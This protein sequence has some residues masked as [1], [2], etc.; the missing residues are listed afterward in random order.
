MTV[1]R[2]YRKDKRRK[3]TELSLELTRVLGDWGHRN[4][5]SVSISITSVDGEPAVKLT[6]SDDPSVTYFMKKNAQAIY[7]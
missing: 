2:T 7:N 4:N 3:L 6:V 1:T 5:C